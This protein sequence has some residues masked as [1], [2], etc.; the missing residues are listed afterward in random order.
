MC[1]NGDTGVGKSH[2]TQ[3]LLQR[4]PQVVEHGPIPQAEILG[5]QQLVH[6]TIQLS[7]DATSNAFFFNGVLAIDA[8]LG[9]EYSKSPEAMGRSS[10]NTAMSYFIHLLKL[11]RLLLLVIEE[12]Q[13][14]NLGHKGFQR[15]LDGLVLQLMNYGI[16]IVLIGN[17]AGIDVLMSQ[18]QAVRRLCSNGT[19]RIDPVLSWTDPIWVDEYMT[20]IWK[21]TPLSEL[22]ECWCS[23]DD[24]SRLVWQATAGFP[25][26]MANLREIAICNAMERDGY[27]VEKQDLRA[28]LESESYAGG[29]YIAEPWVKRDAAL[30]SSRFRDTDCSYYSERWGDA[31]KAE[32]QWLR[33]RGSGGGRKPAGLSTDD[34]SSHSGATPDR[35]SGSA[36]RQG[37]RTGKTPSSGSASKGKSKDSKAERSAPSATPSGSNSACRDARSPDWLDDQPKQIDL[38]P[39]VQ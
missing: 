7:G 3:H 23:E 6:L 20:G 22:D 35:E 28:A 13:E 32:D 33:S 16:P 34:E 25:G 19:Y 9:T 36:Q 26:L 21:P 2:P 31:M 29:R 27:R 11:H 5:L 24:L 38:L 10:K 1:I 15:I 39:P 18:S 30:L 37:A 12:G 14:R 17:P 4:I 8:A